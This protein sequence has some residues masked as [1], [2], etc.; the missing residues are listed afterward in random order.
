M[1]LQILYS[2]SLSLSL[3]EYVFISSS[4]YI[5]TSVFVFTPTLQHEQDQIKSQ[6]KSGVKVIGM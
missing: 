4:T 5:Y 3:S 2:L 6:I 1:L